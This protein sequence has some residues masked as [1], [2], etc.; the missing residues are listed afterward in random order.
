MNTILLTNLFIFYGLFLM[1]CGITAIIFIG[2]KA[3]TALISGGTSG[4]IALSIAYSASQ[5]FVY[6]VYLGIGLTL[7]LFVIFSWRGTKTL[8]LLLE[9]TAEKHEDVKGKAIAFLIIGLMAVV[10]LFVFTLQVVL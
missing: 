4:M 5:N 1:M 2:L 6:A 7:F 3:K 8:L 10:T 9:L